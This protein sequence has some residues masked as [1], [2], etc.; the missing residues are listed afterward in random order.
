MLD[1]VVE[2]FRDNVEK[3]PKNG[4][5]FLDCTLGGGGHAYKLAQWIGN[6]G[7]YIGIDQD[8]EAIENASKRLNTLSKD[9]KPKL[10]LVQDNFSNIDDVLS[11][12]PVDGLDGVLMDLGVSSYQIDNTDRGF[13]FKQNCILDM[14]MNPQS[15]ISA[16]DV[17]NT[18]SEYDLSNLIYKYSD[19]IYAKK[20]ASNIVKSRKTQAI[21]TSDQLVEIIKNSIPAR[22]RRHGGHP[23]KRTF[24]ALRIEVNDEIKKLND[25]LDQIIKWLN[26]GGVIAIIS[27]HSLEDRIV[28]SKFKSCVNRCACPKTLPKCVCGRKPIFNIITNKPIMAKDSEVKEN[29]R[30]RSAKLRV[31]KR[32]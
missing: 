29:R 20:I 14:R 13:S 15:E 7:L 26:T 10:E 22:A 19:E 9:E 18:Y 5:V 6:N 3:Q 28:K 30:S 27:Y 11:S 1:E 23:A 31:A 17:V 8:R 4:I 12:I 32:I 25:A 24:Q 16:L 2:A 21:K